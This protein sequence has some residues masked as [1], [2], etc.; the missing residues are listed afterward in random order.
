MSVCQCFV[1]YNFPTVI[2]SC[3]TILSCVTPRF[4][5]EYM[6]RVG[7]LQLGST[8]YLYY[9]MAIGS[10]AHCV[11]FCLSTCPINSACTCTGACI[12]ERMCSRKPLV[13][14]TLLIL[15]VCW[16]CV[17]TCYCIRIHTHTHK[18]CSFISA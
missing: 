1:I 3:Q 4:K 10:H 7:G 16:R 12:Y 5:E 14:F 15:G 11:G 18:F 9:G 17:I 8:L 6:Y 13:N 2:S